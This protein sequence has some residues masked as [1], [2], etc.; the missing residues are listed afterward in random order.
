MSRDITI[1]FAFCL[2]QTI[3][4]LSIQGQTF[5]DHAFTRPSE[6]NTAG[7]HRDRAFKTRATLIKAIETYSDHLLFPQA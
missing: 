1:Q 5:C 6:L 4:A 7:I 2:E 3:T